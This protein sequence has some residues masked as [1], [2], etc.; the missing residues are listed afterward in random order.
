MDM[1]AIEV[2]ESNNVG[3]DVPAK[4]E[5]VLSDRRNGVAEVANKE[6]ER[7]AVQS[8]ENGKIFFL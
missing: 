4:A 8:H 6:A 5:V 1:D 2:V 7:V 3:A